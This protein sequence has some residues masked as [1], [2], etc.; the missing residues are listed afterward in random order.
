ML[1]PLNFEKDLPKNINPDK[2]ERVVP[3]PGDYMENGILHCGVCREEKEMLIEHP[4]RGYVG[5]ACSCKEKAYE[6]SRERDKANQKR[7]R[8]AKLRDAGFHEAALKDCCFEKDDYSNPYVTGAMKNFVDDFPK[9][10]ISGQGLLL[11]GA[12]GT[13]KT[14]AAV[15]VANALLDKAI[16]VVVT[17]MSRIATELSKSGFNKGDYIETL[18]ECDLLVIDDLGRERNTEYMVEVIGEVIDSRVRAKKPMIITTNLSLDEV[19]KPNDIS[20]Q[21]IYDR[22]LQSCMP[23]EVINTNRRYADVR[24]SYEEKRREMFRPR[25]ENERPNP[26]PQNIEN[27]E[28]PF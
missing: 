9:H 3:N 11:Y 19:K 15:C 4:K 13:G 22:I 6:Q 23:L 21:R 18:N 10:I 7:L 26:K 28:I 8:I 25:P 5:I 27:M 1:Q 12:C 24:K 17:S 2:I 20:K 16:P 14:F